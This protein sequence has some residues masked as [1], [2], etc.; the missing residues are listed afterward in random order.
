MSC[1]RS[2]QDFL[3]IFL[4]AKNLSVLVVGG[5]KVAARKAKTALK[6]GAEVKIVAPFF[7]KTALELDKAKRVFR[8]FRFS[9]LRGVRLIFIATDDNVLNRQITAVA[10]KKGILANTASSPNEGRVFMPSTWKSGRL[11]VALTTGGSSP[12]AAV[13]LRNQLRK[14][15]CR[16]WSVYLDLLEALRRKIVKD[17]I[18][19]DRRRKILRRLGDPSPWLLMIRRHGRQKTSQAMHKIYRQRL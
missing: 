6:A 11:V 10:E 9:D 3:P 1:S 14:K 15:I 4:R 5:G 18:S 8:K 12:A 17:G 13:A 7:S 16:E 19:A 2:S